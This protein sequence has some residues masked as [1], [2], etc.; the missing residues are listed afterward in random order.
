MHPHRVFKYIIKDAALLPAPQTK[1]QIIINRGGTLRHK[2]PVPLT[3]DGVTL[4]VLH[5]IVA[6]GKFIRIKTPYEQESRL[7]LEFDLLSPTVY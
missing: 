6:R 7:A 1:I 2:T 5:I 4:T 3:L